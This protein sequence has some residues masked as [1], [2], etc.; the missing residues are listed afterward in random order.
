MTQENSLFLHKLFI[1]DKEILASSSGSINF[2]GNNNLN[3]MDIT[4]DNI[5]L[6]HDSFL[7]KKVEFFLEFCL[8]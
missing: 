7:N 8:S 4:I 5:D 2:S 6:Q 3:Q 1:D